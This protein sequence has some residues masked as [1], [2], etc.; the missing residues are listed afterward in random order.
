MGTAEQHLF[1]GSNHELL[2]VRSHKRDHIGF[3]AVSQADIQPMFGKNPFF[4]RDVKRCELHI[5]DIGQVECDLLQ[6]GFRISGSAGMQ[7]QT[8]DK[9]DKE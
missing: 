4:N 2:V 1:T 7:R 9:H 3:I 8:K 6:R 5:R